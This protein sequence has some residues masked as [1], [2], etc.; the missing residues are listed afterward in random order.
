MRVVVFPEPG[1][2]KSNIFSLELK[3]SF[4]EIKESLAFSL[5][6]SFLILVVID[7][8]KV[9]K[10][11]S[12]SVYGG[13]P[14]DKKINKLINEVQL[15]FLN[16]LKPSANIDE[17][18][19]GVYFLKNTNKNIIGIFKPIDEEAFAPN[20]QKGYI[21]KFGQPSFRKGILSGEGSIRE[22]AATLFD[23]DKHMFKIPETTF[24]EISH[25]SFSNNSKN[26]DMIN[27]KYTS[28]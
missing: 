26:L 6:F 24:V 7:N 3:M 27:G 17:G 4:S 22:V 21:G 23:K 1:S 11:G 18:T 12:I 13:F 20:N 16:N 25:E 10:L 14:N 2:P 9:N 19:S 5:A 15:G 8:S 28:K